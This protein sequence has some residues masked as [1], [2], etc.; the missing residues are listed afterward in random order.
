MPHDADIVYHHVNDAILLLQGIQQAQY[1]LL[2][3]QI[4]NL[5]YHTATSSYGIGNRLQ[6]IRASR[7]R[8]YG[9]PGICR[10]RYGCPAY[11]VRSARDQPGLAREIR[12][13]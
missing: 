6:F 10:G 9:S 12:F 5:G 11:T 4:S 3:R 2:Q 1:L 7:Y 13:G 8:V